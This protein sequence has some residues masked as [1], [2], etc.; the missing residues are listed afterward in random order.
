MSET[1]DPGADD[2]A[3]ARLGY[4]PELRRTLDFLSSFS[5]AFAYISPVVGV[6]TLFGYG[7]ATGGP[8]F[9]W[10]LPVVVL[11]QLLVVLV[12]SELAVAYPLAGALYQW[13]RRLVG[14]RYGWLV[15]WIYG[16]ALVITIAAVDLGA[17]PYLADLLGLAP[18]RGHVVLLAGL[19]VIVHTAVNYEGVRGTAIIGNV[20]LATEVVA[21]VAIAGALLFHPGHPA[22]LRPLSTLLSRQTPTAI[23]GGT[24]LLAAVLAMTWIFYGFES[25]AG[26]AEEV[27]DPRRR[28]PRAMI[29]SLLGAAVVTALLEVALILSAPDLI[30]AAAD[31][32]RTIPLILEAHLG[33]RVLR[34]LL[35]L[36]MFAYLSCAGA[37]QAAAAR[38]M[39]S[40]ARDG[41]VPASAWLRRVS[42][43]HRVPGN[44]IVFSAAAALA[45]IGASYLDVGQVNINALVVSYAVVGVYLSFQAVVAAR[46][47][48]AC[49]GWK[50]EAP[51]GYFT[52]GRW[53]VPVSIAALVY[54]VAMIVNLCWPRPVDALA[55]WLTLLAALAIVV[56]GLVIVRTRRFQGP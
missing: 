33:P 55:S 22:S 47:Y 42:A 9:V 18:T 35:M 7:L 52:L 43:G 17:A 41:M 56:P 4:V 16:W 54:G 46:L 30:Q 1:R 5:I 11:G 31:P 3:L 27:I 44:A 8:A 14:P 32:A 40:Y 26:V 37:A 53:S 19:L 12:F 6:Y 21:T 34:G 23:A 45:V 51:E 48:A 50:A 28:V 49:R 13:A 15:G 38:L 10:G 36:L 24:D 2:K 20:G 25:A 29:L 39:Y